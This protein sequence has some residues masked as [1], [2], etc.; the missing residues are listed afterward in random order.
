M[1]VW[2]IPHLC[3]YMCTGSSAHMYLWKSLFIQMADITAH[4]CMQ[5][6][7]RKIVLSAKWQDRVRNYET[8]EICGN[9]KRLLSTG[10]QDVLKRR[11]QEEKKKRM[12]K[13]KKHL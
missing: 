13:K 10:D 3:T 9:L 11:G 8:N 7:T 6:S 12:I 1:N 4:I 5:L 2:S